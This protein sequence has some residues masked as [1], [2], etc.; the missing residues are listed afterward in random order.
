MTLRLV[1][2]LVVLT[3]QG[4][5]QPSFGDCGGSPEHPRVGLVLSGGGARG[6]AHVGVLRALE[7]HGIVVDCVAG[8]S[9]GALIGAFYASGLPVS[10]IEEIVRSGEWQEMFEAG[11]GLGRRRIAVARRMEGTRSLLRVGI[12]GWKLR[13]PSA[14]ASDYRLN[15]ILFRELAGP[16]FRSAGD[17]NR[18]AVPF[19]AVA[20]DLATTDRVVLA[21]GDLQRA[22]RASLSAPL[23]LP[24]V[25]LDGRQLVDGGTVD[26]MPVGVVREMGAQFVIAVDV[27]SP[28][29]QPEPGDH[30]IEV[31]RV[32]A[33]AL[34][35]ARNDDY[36]AAADVVLTPRLDG[37]RFADH[38]KVEEAI[39]AGLAAG[40]DA[41]AR[42]S[43]PSR[44]PRASDAIA[45]VSNGP[46]GLPIATVRVEGHHGVRESFILQ[47]LGLRAGDPFDTDRALAGID[48]VHATGLFRSS[49]LALRPA[50]GGVDAVLHVEEAQRRT[51]AVGAAYNEG[52]TVS[53]FLRLR[54][55][56]LFGRG[57][58]LEL[59]GRASD[60]QVGLSGTVSVESLGG[61][62][63]GAYANG[64]LMQDK[65]RFFREHEHLGRAKFDRRGFGGGLQKALGEQ[66]LVRAGIDWERVSTRPQPLVDIPEEDE[67]LVTLGGMVLWDDL[68]DR[69]LPRRG[70]RLT[71]A[72]EKSMTGMGASRS[73]SRGQLNGRLAV[74][75]WAR[76]VVQLHLLA[77]LTD[78]DLP[79]A[80]WTRLGGPVLVPGLHRE[81]L[82]GPQALALA[83]SHS[84]L[85]TKDLRLTARVGAGE[86][87]QK[88]SDVSLGALRSGVGLGLELPTRLGPIDAEVGR[89]M[90]SWRF[91][92]AVGYQ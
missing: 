82:W 18:L 42:G 66:A 49:W 43:L 85:L 67:R 76:S 90:G 26:N 21:T 22:V 72:A 28:I 40:V 30:A 48:A 2:P 37:I 19:R 41:I 44:P 91:S 50:G 34:M 83:I 17:F 52:D 58:S 15:R 7:D 35:R 65:P 6:M 16:G 5:V 79:V 29:L 57:E 4:L 10:R 73:Y 47:S 69:W 13:L 31:G 92:L 45:P 80:E 11:G 86:V 59:S 39:A 88:R 71:F 78:G 77:A 64:R 8:T 33:D 75:P 38:D 84:L 32:L 9:A 25:S 51:L 1:P 56:N 23:L 53:G 70:V 63:F 46:D 60:S 3:L 87:W 36:S 74:S 14:A 81:E 55:A 54:D 61:L 24:P 12:D 68:D 27:R 89:S 20:A 62:G